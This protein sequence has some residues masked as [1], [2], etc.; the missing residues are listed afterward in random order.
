MN[1]RETLKKLIKDNHTSQ[2]ELATKMGYSNNTGISRIG[3]RNNMNTDTLIKLCDIL[4]YEVILKPK[5][6]EDR[7]ARTIV[8]SED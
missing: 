7:Q 2:S 5:H 3:Q 1:V 6:G 4:G 8:L